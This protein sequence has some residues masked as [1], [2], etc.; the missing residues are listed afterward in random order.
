MKYP[1]HSSVEYHVAAGNLRRS[2]DLP[3]PLKFLKGVDALHTSQ[4]LSI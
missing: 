1:E 3:I 2:E 4:I